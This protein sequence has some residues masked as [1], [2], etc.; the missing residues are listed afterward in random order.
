MYQCWNTIAVSMN[1]KKLESKKVHQKGSKSCGDQ[2]G[3]EMN[4]L[5]LRELGV[6]NTYICGFGRNVIQ[7]FFYTSAFNNKQNIDLQ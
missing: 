4:S 7:L 3:I 6:Q 1:I 5:Q 2:R